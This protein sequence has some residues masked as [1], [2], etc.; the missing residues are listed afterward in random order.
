MGLSFWL[1]LLVLFY[2]ELSKERRMTQLAMN[3]KTQAGTTSGHCAVSSSPAEFQVGREV[4]PE[5]DS[6]RP[7]LS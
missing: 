4:V 1:S 5:A 6:K 3:F 2:E 7:R